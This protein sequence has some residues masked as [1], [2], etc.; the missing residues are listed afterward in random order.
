MIAWIILPFMKSAIEALTLFRSAVAFETYLWLNGENTEGEPTQRPHEWVIVVEESCCLRRVRRRGL[1]CPRTLSWTEAGTIVALQNA[2]TSS[3]LLITLLNLL[4]D[5]V[6]TVSMCALAIQPSAFSVMQRDHHWN[7]FFSQTYSASSPG[8]RRLQSLA[9]HL[10]HLL[11]RKSS[12]PSLGNLQGLQLTHK[13]QTQ[14][15]LRLWRELGVFAHCLLKN[16]CAL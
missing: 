12:S 3:F 15:P 14:L 13:P 7:A 2:P 6:S 16:W 8:R 10:L 1:T 5:G 4:N 11:G 9:A